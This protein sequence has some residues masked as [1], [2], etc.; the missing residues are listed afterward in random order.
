[1]TAVIETSPS[2]TGPLQE[3][4]VPSRLDPQARLYVRALGGQPRTGGTPVV[5]VHGFFQ[6]ASAILDVQGYSLLECLAAAGLRTYLFDFRGYGRSSRPA[7]MDLAP[8]ASLPSLGCMDDALA[9]LRD[10]VSFVLAQEGV[11]RVDLLGYSWG[12]ARSARYALTEKGQIRRLALYAP[13]WR[14]VTGAASTA[15]APGRPGVL[16][17]DWGGYT[18]FRPG[19]LRKSWDWEIAGLAPSLFRGERV[20]EAAEGALMDSDQG[21]P[22]AGFRAPLGP[23]VDAL[24][25]ARGE[26]LFDAGRIGHE[27]LLLRGAQDHLSTE[28]DAG[29]LFTA[30]GSRRKRLVTIGYG[31]HLLHLEHARDQLMQELIA[32]LRGPESGRG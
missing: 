12:T 25:V 21:W 13:V 24:S 32:F 5:L 17:P 26:A 2:A 27:V 6:P 20:L 30:L 22:E 7:F 23:M 9:D 31:T 18:T 4:Y 14:P 16:N 1:M 8:E 10:I 15:S 3:W 11:D 19:D 29:A 28:T